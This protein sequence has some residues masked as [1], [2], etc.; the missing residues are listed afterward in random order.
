MAKQPSKK[1]PAKRKSKAKAKRPRG[2]PEK[3][4]DLDELEKLAAIHCTYEDIAGWFGVAKMT[5]IRRMKRADYRKRYEDGIAKG[6]VSLRRSQFKL[7]EKNA[8][9][10]IFLGKQYLDQKDEREHTVKNPVDP[11]TNE[12][13]PFTI[14][15]ADPTTDD[16]E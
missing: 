5:V 3:S 8:T 15:F 10:A 2:R 13:I 14:T 9:M 1:A 11:G 4:I 16:I 7:A 12:V 6:R